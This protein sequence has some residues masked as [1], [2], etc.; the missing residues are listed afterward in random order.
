MPRRPCTTRPL[1]IPWRISPGDGITRRA[2]FISVRSRD[3]GQLV[4]ET[5]SAVSQRN[6]DES[7][8]FPDPRSTPCARA[9]LSAMASVVSGDLWYR[10]DNDRLLLVEPKVGPLSALITPPARVNTEKHI[11]TLFSSAHWTTGWRNAA[12]RYAVAEYRSEAI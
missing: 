6:Q 11:S 2:P 3:L 1:S 5:R 8:V 7:L 9:G 12:L 10:S 4:L